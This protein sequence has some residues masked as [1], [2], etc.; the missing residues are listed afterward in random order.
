MKIEKMHISES[1]IVAYHHKMNLITPFSKIDGNYL[2]QF[3]NLLLSDSKSHLCFVAKEKGAIVGAIT[4]T[5]DL[6]T[7]NKILRGLVS[8][9]LIFNTIKAILLGKLAINEIFGRLQ[10]EKYLL[11]STSRTYPSILTLFVVDGYQRKG[12]GKSLI[13]TT[14]KKLERQ[15]I[16][17]VYVDTLKTNKKAIIFYKSL[18]FTVKNV[19][20]DSIILEY[21]FFN[22][23]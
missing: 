12:I 2:E 3:Y 6:H 21:H 13:K 5:L 18:G 11:K 19:I 1:K 22:S 7:T 15:K 10:F 4:T 14:L 9:F 23:N 17:K 8:P 16:K 20:A